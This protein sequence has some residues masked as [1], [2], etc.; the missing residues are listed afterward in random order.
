MASLKSHPILVVEAPSWAQHSLHQP[1]E[2]TASELMGRNNSQ[3]TSNS[4]LKT[5]DIQSGQILTVPGTKCPKLINRLIG[6]GHVKGSQKVRHSYQ[7]PIY[8]LNYFSH[9]TTP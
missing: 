3:K 6:T 5:L 9:P 1:T 2:T 8:L 4:V 7:C